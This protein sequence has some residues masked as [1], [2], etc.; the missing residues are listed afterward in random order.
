MYIPIKFPISGSR[1]TALVFRVSHEGTKKIVNGLIHMSDSQINRGWNS[2]GTGIYGLFQSSG[3][4]H[5][6]KGVV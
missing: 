6:S 5:M 4:V 1:T 3:P 2:C